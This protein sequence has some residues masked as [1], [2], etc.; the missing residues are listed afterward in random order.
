L[1][2]G[3]TYPCSR[4]A[5]LFETLVSLHDRWIRPVDGWRPK[6][7][8][9][10]ERRAELAAWLLARWPVAWW[11]SKIWSSGSR[12]S[13]RE[14][15]LYLHLTSG[16]SLRMYEPEGGQMTAA[17]R[18]HTVNAPMRCA[19]ASAFRYGVARGSGADESLAMTIALATYGGTATAGPWREIIEWAARR[20][21][22]AQADT[23]ELVRYID[24]EMTERARAG[25]PAYSIRGRTVRSV[26]RAAREWQDR[27]QAEAAEALRDQ[28]RRLRSWAPCGIREAP[29]TRVDGKPH[30]IIELTTLEQLMDEG[31]TQRHCVGSYAK[32]AHAGRCAIFSLRDRRDKSV[33]TL[34]VNLGTRRVVQ[35]RGQQN[36]RPTDEEA[37]AVE[38][39]VARAGLAWTER[40]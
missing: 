30:R 14:I 8:A 26:A 4:T 22:F 1:G 23:R 19:Y 32:A 31:V 28:D 2:T 36:R 13:P 5:E 6:R 37:R 16:Q 9:L 21:E 20:P 24:H 25:Q 40:W 27:L 35:V 7:V 34:E 12:P 10:F 39:W 18:H 17:M 33:L 15:A 11:L 3:D 29:V 38:S